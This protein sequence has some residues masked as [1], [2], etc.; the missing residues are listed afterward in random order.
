VVVKSTIV[1]AK[2]KVFITPRTSTDK[3]IAVTSIKANE[4]F[5]VE[6]GSASATDIVVDYLIVGVE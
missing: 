3:T 4:S 2:S 6:L 5:M 1:T